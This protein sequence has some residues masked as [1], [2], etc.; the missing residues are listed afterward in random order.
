MTDAPCCQFIVRAGQFD[1]VAG[2]EREAMVLG[3]S[4]LAH[5]C[6]CRLDLGPVDRFLHTVY[7]HPREDVRGHAEKVDTVRIVP[8]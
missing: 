4:V 5:S 7:T 6:Q 3:A 1:K 8:G 2:M